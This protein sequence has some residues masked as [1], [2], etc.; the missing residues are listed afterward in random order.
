MR[1]KINREEILEA[2]KTY[3]AVHGYP[4]TNREL[5]EKTGYSLSSVN[6]CLKSMLKEGI[7]ETDHPLGSPRAIRVPGM[8]SVDIGKLKEVCRQLTDLLEHCRD[9]ANGMGAD[10]IWGKDVEALE[11]VIGVIQTGERRNDRKRKLDE[12]DSGEVETIGGAYE[13][14]VYSGMSESQTDDRGDRGDGT[15]LL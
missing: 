4:P 8:R 6:G 1:K 2:V 7:L 5:A 3:I 9:M 12:R 15:G 11:T 10:P 14:V 13:K